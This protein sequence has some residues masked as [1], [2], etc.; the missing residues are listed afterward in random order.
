MGSSARND[1][2]EG[3]ACPHAIKVSMAASSKSGTKLDFQ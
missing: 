1:V 3:A 2:G